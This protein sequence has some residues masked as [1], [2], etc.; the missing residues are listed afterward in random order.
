MDGMIFDIQR[1]SL[2]DGPGIRTTVFLK[3][4]GMRCAWCHNPEGLT[5]GP[6]IMF[7]PQK[8]VGCGKCFQLCPNGCH[9]ME[10]SSRVFDRTRCVRCGACAA[11]CWAGAL[12]MTGRCV[13]AQEVVEEIAKDA[14]FYENSGGGA[15]FSGGEPLRQ[16]DFLLEMLA[17][18]KERGFTC[19][20]E[21]AGHVPWKAFEKV[22]PLT[23]LFLYDLKIVDGALH[24]K[25]T[26]AGN[27]RILNNLRRLAGRA[28][29]LI[30]RTPEI[31]GVNDT[32]E[33]KEQLAALLVSLGRRVEHVYL[34]YH[35]LG[36][37]KYESLGMKKPAFVEG[38]NS[39][40]AR[41]K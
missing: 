32:P 7:Y 8:C 24:Q 12:V 22:L 6:E 37:G 26:G 3:G 23:D 38:K 40:N 28:K 33:E 4:C 1:F 31:P 17:G 27:E 25:M 14:L 29:Q 13:S 36:N 15:T 2:D 19:A 10:D 18:C 5:A 41:Q 11:Q 21:T 35:A 16:P 9:R 30:V 34:P 20:I 39:K